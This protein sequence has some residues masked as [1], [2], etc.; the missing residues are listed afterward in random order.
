MTP[1]ICGSPVQSEA[2]VEVTES[3]NELRIALPSAQLLHT[4]LLHSATRHRPTSS[5]LS[6]LLDIK[7]A[8]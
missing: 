1:Q 5:M 2:Y 8:S 3:L 6:G 7:E 4:F